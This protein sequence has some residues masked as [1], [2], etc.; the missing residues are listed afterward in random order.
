MHLSPVSA[1]SVTG[2]LDDT[3]NSVT[4]IAGAAVSIPILSFID[5]III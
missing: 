3:T 4:Q 1:V 2:D 5:L